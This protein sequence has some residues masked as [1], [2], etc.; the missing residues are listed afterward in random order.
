MTDGRVFVSELRTGQHTLNELEMVIRTGLRTFVQVGEALAEIR[1]RRLYREQ[2]FSRFEDYCHER[3]GWNRDY[4]NKQIRAAD[5]VRNLDTTVSIPVTERQ[6]R[7][8]TA[9]SPQQQREVWANAVAQSPNGQPTAAGVEAVIKKD[10]LPEGRPADVQSEQ[11]ANLM[12]EIEESIKASFANATMDRQ[13][14]LLSLEEGRHKQE[15]QKAKADQEADERHARDLR[16]FRGLYDAVQFIA[17]FYEEPKN[18]WA[19]LSRVCAYDFSSH[20]TR[21]IQQL[22]RLDREH[23]NEP[24][25]PRILNKKI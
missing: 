25:K 21:A 19:G 13:G 1:D 17:G 14:R 5:V 12:A 20:L 15:I 22:V 23:P 4:A 16:L 9:L 6:V 11:E 8:L 18:T 10:F 3:W 2:G 7:P 24:R